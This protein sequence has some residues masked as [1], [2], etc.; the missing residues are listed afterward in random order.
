M[1]SAGAVMLLV[2]SLSSSLAASFVGAADVAFAV[3]SRVIFEAISL[4][5]P[6]AVSSAMSA[7]MSGE[8]YPRSLE[9]PQ[10]KIELSNF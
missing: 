10:V 4:T 8:T 1:P 6:N 5:V 7:T 3:R 2:T 9:L